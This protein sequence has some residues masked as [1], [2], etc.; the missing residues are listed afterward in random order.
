M[1][2]RIATG[3]AL[4]LLWGA[5]AAW[6]ALAEGEGEAD[7]DKAIEAKLGVDSEEPRVR[8]QQL[9]QV[10]ELCQSALD[11]GLDEENKEFADTL[12]ASTLHERAELIGQVIFQADTTD[13]RFLQ[14]YPALWQ[15]AVRDA[16]RA[17]EHD[18]E[19]PET[20]YLLGRLQALPGGD[21]K[22]AIKSLDVAIDL[23][24][25][26]DDLRAKALLARGALHE[27]SQ[28]RLE[29]YNEALRLDPENAAALRARGVEL[30][31]AGKHEEGI[32]DLDA[33]LKLAP[34]DAETHELRGAALTEMQK[35]DEAIEALDKALDLNPRG[36]SA[37][38]RRGQVRL[39]QKQPKDALIDFDKVLL[40]QPASLK[41]LLLRAAAHQQLGDKKRAL[42][43]VDKVLELRPG[44]PQALRARAALAA[45]EGDFEEA[46]A[47]LE[48]AVEEAPQDA[49]TLLQLGL[50]YSA[51]GPTK[52]LEKAIESFSAAIEA[53]PKL[54]L[55]WQ[56][57]G[58][59]YI[60]TG[61]HEE[62]LADYE[63]ALKLD[64]KSTGVLN[65]M[66]WLLS[67]SPDEKLRD[68]QRAIKLAMQACELTDYKAA[69]ILSTLAAGY[70]E[71]GD[72]ETAI[73]WSS[74]AVEVSDDEEIDDQ[75]QNELASYK[76]GKPWRERQTN[77]GGDQETPPA[78]WP[79][80]VDLGAEGDEGP[81]LNHV[82]DPRAGP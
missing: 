29:D 7:L 81:A 45:G 36:A 40:L 11:K 47:D 65:N 68:G 31:T 60:S 1:L 56:S 61:R 23:S 77:G 43:D 13:P 58:D 16:K 52:D 42:A 75:L 71:T 48:K 73:K 15:A 9:G 18:L 41:A 12:L 70:A 59:I 8:L 24:K 25:K 55:A 19:Q 50:F 39:L 82:D 22:D 72:F 79:M 37:Y 17:L 69:H 30:F 53:D 6:P 33:A 26:D 62:A 49:E 46:I 35:Y 78:D 63:E 3:F 57:R 10:I 66:A 51:P 32:T 5:A 44:L 74:K 54:A 67:T 27:D 34:D 21:R 4:V 14:Q 38:L 64:A 80:R 76:A 20:H 28:A 2:S